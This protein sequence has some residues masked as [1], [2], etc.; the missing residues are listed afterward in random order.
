[1][2]S[3]ARRF[4]SDDFEITANEF[5]SEY[6]DRWAAMMRQAASTEAKVQGLVEALE[7]IL[8]I[9]GFSPEGAV[10][11]KALSKFLGPFWYWGGPY[12]P[13]INSKKPA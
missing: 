6:H 12:G 2:T 1:M 3:E 10:A 4:S 11:A 5:D 13:V 8:K 9:G 7:C